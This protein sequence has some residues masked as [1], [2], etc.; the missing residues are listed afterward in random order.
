MPDNRTLMVLLVPAKR[1]A[2]PTQVTV[3][4]AKLAGEYGPPGL[5]R[6]FQDL[7]KTPYDED[8]FEYYATAQLAMIDS[9]A[10]RFSSVGAPASSVRSMSLPMA[11]ISS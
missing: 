4:G 10:E 7:L 3:P 9:P 1:A 5:V 6:T 8:L 2:A 11:T